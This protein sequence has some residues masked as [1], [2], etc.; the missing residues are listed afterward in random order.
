MDY[1]INKPWLSL[2]PW[3]K[4]YIDEKGNCFLCCGRQSGK[5]TAASIKIAECAVAEKTPGDYLVIALTEK[6]AYNLFFKTL[7]Y[8][9]ARHPHMIKRGKDKPTMHEINLK[10][11][12]SIMCYAAGN[13]G[14]TLRTFTIKKLFVDEAAPMAREIFIAVSPML[15]VTGG[16]MDLLS[17]PRGKE[18]YFYDCS[19]RDD[20]KKFYVSAEDCPRHDKKFLEAEKTRMSKLE[21]AQEYLAVFLD[22]LRRMFSDELIKDCCVLKRP[23]K[24]E[25]GKRYFCGIDVAAMGMDES[26]F[27]ILDGSNREAIKQVE[28][29]T[30]TKTRTTETTQKVLGLER[31]YKFRKIGIDDGGLGVAVFDALLRE[32][33]TKKKIISLNNARRSLDRDDKSHKRL[34]KEDMYMNLL[35]LMEHKKIKLLD[36]DELIASLKSV[37]Y[38]YVV[39]ENEKTRMRIFGDYTHIAE[40]IIRAAWLVVQ[41]KRLNIWVR[42]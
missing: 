38:E 17:T 23:N 24:V 9:E 25:D 30:T 14:D 40:G 8:L 18:G 11:G 28:S 22:E 35:A 6:Q 12:V 29:I 2:D 27:E 20:F 32:D 16:T 36:D 10:N 26:T 3:Q 37:Q 41:E 31:T 1:D 13:T 39:K 4:E 33:S 5:T 15:S 42:Y 19:L 21:Y 7:M 34:I